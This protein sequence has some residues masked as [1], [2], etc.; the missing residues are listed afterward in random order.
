[1]S[2]K[3]ITTGVQTAVSRRQFLTGVSSVT[4]AAA[5]GPTLLGATNKSGSKIVLG[6]GSH[7]YELIEGWGQLQSGVKY[8]YTHGVQI[9]SHNRVII[10]N[11]SKDSVII[12]DHMESTSSHGDRSSRRV[13]TAA[14]CA[15]KPAR[16]ISI[17]P[18]TSGTWW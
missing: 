1:M 7:T 12:F 16:N 9:D 17:F 14:C 4:A 8:G 11:Q 13:R 18:T 3:T 6:S 10:Y 5:W 15:G 2:R